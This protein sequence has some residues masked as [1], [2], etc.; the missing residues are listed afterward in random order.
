MGPHAGSNV[1]N[2]GAGY[3]LSKVSSVVY[4]GFGGRAGYHE[5]NVESLQILYWRQIQIQ[6]RGGSGSPTLMPVLPTVS[7]STAG[8]MFTI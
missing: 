1:P 2:D 5:Y 4:L 6:F 7:L 3:H 8:S